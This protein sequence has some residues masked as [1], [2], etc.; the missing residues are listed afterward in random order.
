MVPMAYTPTAGAVTFRPLRP[1][2]VLR[3]F[4]RVTVNDFDEVERITVPLTFTDVGHVTCRI[5]NHALS[6]S[7]VNA[8]GTR[9]GATQKT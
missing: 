6:N 8:T 4:V 1:R 3:T 7:S 9:D 2:I 5:E